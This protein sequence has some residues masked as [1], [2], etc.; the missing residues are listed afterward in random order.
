MSAGTRSVKRSDLLATTAPA[1]PYS[2]LMLMCDRVGSSAYKLPAHGPFNCLVDLQG[3]RLLCD[4]LRPRLQSADVTVD[5]PDTA[6]REIDSICGAAATCGGVREW[7]ERLRAW[8]QGQTALIG[9]R[10]R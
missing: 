7:M 3:V 10:R 2:K 9:E 4:I 5:V 8:E 6:M 1:D